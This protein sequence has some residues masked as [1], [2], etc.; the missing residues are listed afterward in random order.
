MGLLLALVVFAAAVASVP[1][2]AVRAAREMDG[3]GRDGR[4]YGLLVL[5]V[6]PIGL[7]IWGLDRRRYRGGPDADAGGAGSAASGG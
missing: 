2:L 1:M 3:L 5:V 4:M 7:L 6:F